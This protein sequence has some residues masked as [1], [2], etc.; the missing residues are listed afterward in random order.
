MPSQ[1]NG[2]MTHADDRIRM[3][4]QNCPFLIDRVDLSEG[5][6]YIMHQATASIRD[7]ELSDAEAASVFAHLNKMAELDVD[8]QNLLV[9]GVLEVLTDTPQSIERTRAG[10]DGGAARFLFERVLKGWS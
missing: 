6:Y 1:V 8:T 5:P 4:L 9:V 2:A 7:G 3:L 10:L